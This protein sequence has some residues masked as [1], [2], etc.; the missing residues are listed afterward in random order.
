MY[1][2]REHKRFIMMWKLVVSE[3]LIFVWPTLK[4]LLAS[5]VQPSIHSFVMS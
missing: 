3:A 1:N 2:I 4:Q 5:S